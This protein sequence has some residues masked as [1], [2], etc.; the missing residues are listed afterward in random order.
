MIN[1]M[2][3]KVKT[4][5]HVFQGSFFPHAVYYRKITRSPFSFSL[6]YFISL[7]F[8]LNFI[9]FCYVVLKYN[10]T[11]LNNFLVNL[12]QVTRSIPKE[13]VIN[14]NNGALFT[15]YN[16][17][18]FFWLKNKDKKNLL[19]VID[20]TASPEKIDTYN[21]YIL[22]TNREIVIK[23]K[24]SSL[25]DFRIFPL[26]NFNKKIIDQKDFQKTATFFTFLH[27]FFYFFYFIAIFCLFIFLPLLS[28]GITFFYLTII[29]LLVYL[30]FKTYYHKKIHFKKTLQLSFHAVTL[31]LLLDYFLMIFKPTFPVNIHSQ[32][33]I[34]APLIF[35]ILLT[36]FVFAAVY[37]AY[38]DQHLPNHKHHSS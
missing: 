27:N 21:S 2:R 3:R 6:K 16:R 23:K 32:L 22:I 17:P 1:L 33:S 10:P 14:I 7:I 8:I 4:F 30:F 18:Y 37:E 28:L 35:L 20:E 34:P 9:F 24:L 5:F 38:Q 19:L 12:T 13:L 25:K 31:P 26:K 36:I 29:S 11:R 15:N